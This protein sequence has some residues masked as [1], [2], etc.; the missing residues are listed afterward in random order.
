MVTMGSKLIFI[1]KWRTRR[2]SKYGSV[3]FKN[4]SSKGIVGYH[5]VVNW[6]MVRGGGLNRVL[7]WFKDGLNMVQGSL[8]W[9]KDGCQ[10]VS[11]NA[12]IEEMWKGFIFYLRGGS[13][14][15]TILLFV[16]IA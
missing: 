12:F 9:F 2:W 1:D 5:L 3:W 16:I 6:F 14:V 15:K 13:L 10:T 7:S 11:Q 8:G 4:G